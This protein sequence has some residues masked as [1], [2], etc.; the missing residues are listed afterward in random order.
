MNSMKIGE[1]AKLS[2]TAAETIRFYEREGLLREPARSQGNYRLY[3]RE[4]VR[5]LAFIR[6]CRTLDMSLA[7][8]RALLDF[9]DEPQENCGAV[10]EVLDE[11]IGRVARRIRD[12]KHLQ[13]ELLALRRQCDGVAEHCGILE[14][15]NSFPV[16]ANASGDPAKARPGARSQM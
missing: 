9:G 5:R 10:N 11:H 6:H 13:A 3:G 15:L 16:L 12:L 14:G 1:L 7:E 2:H 8:I 4:H